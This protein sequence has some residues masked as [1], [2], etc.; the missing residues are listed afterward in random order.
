MSIA[1]TDEAKYSELDTFMESLP[2]NDGALI[3]ALHHAQELFGHLPFEVQNHIAHKLRIPTAKVYG[4][5]TFY[6]FFNIEPKGKYKIQVCMGTA[7]F[8]RG[9]GKVLDEFAKKLNVQPGA[10]SEDKLWSLDGL[11]CVGACGLAP[12]V[13]VNGKVYGRVEVKDV[14]NI[15]DESLA[16][17]E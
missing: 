9:A 13:T 12:V 8:V 17:G 14:Q 11:R 2:S 15:I 7:C 10:T 16:K 1:T 4:V 5:V 6:S 3:P